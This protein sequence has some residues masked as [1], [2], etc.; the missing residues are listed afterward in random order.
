MS[1]DKSV[2]SSPAKGDAPEKPQASGPELVG[3]SEEKER[4][5]KK[6]SKAKKRY[7]RRAL[8]TGIGAAA[9][10][11]LAIGVGGALGYDYLTEHDDRPGSKNY[12]VVD[13]NPSAEF[14]DLKHPMGIKDPLMQRYVTFAKFDMAKGTIQQDLQ[15]LLARWTAAASLL[16]AG[17]P[18]GEV[19]PDYSVRDATPGDTGELYDMY[20]ANL[21]ITFGLGPSLFDERFGIAAHKPDKLVELPRITGDR[22][23]DSVGSDFGIQ[24]C[25]DDPQVVFHALRGL[26]RMARPK[27]NLTYVH[28]GF[29]PNRQSA[30]QTIPRDLFGFRDGTTNPTE[31]NEF[32]KYIWVNESDQPW[33]VGGSY[34]VYRR[35]IID[36]ESWDADRISDQE[37]LIGRRKDTNAPLTGTDEYDLPDLDAV[38]ENG[39]HIIPDGCHVRITSDQRLGFKVLRRAYN[40]WNG[41]N[42]HGKQDAGFV[43]IVYVND[44]EHFYHLRDDMGRYDQLNEYYYDDQSG[45]YVVAQAPQTGH[46]IGQEFFD[47]ENTDGEVSY[48]FSEGDD[49]A[50]RSAKKE[51][52]RSADQERV[53]N[54]SFQRDSKNSDRSASSDAKASSS[55]E[56]V[57]KN[58]G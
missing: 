12:N 25:A 52:Q 34:M 37:H 1:A 10:G 26:A 20:T 17:K 29:L 41:L 42:D 43:N 18:L 14:Y 31:D 21:S 27:A 54:M 56:K 6:A 13:L 11:G 15:V 57:I 47:K 53:Y 33:V 40:F 38:D 8:I 4:R 58:L 39:N 19:R 50:T 5:E 30:K 9:V 48:A 32:D 51:A 28:N 16:M 46:Y 44:P 45:L 24:I 36:I 23:K 2:E 7:S 35:T 49:A 3:E 55:G 22:I